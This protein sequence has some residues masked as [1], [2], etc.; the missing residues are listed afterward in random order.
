MCYLFAY[1]SLMTKQSVQSHS[2]QQTLQNL[3]CG[4]TPVAQ[5]HSSITIPMSRLISP[6][7]KFSAE[8]FA[9]IWICSH[10]Q[11]RNEG[12]E[13]VG[14]ASTWYGGAAGCCK[15]GPLS[16]CHDTWRQRHPPNSC[17]TCRTMTEGLP[18]SGLIWDTM[19]KSV[20]RLLQ[21]QCHVDN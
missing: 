1:S 11:Q 18:G 5:Q 17:V 12:K 6:G 8:D 21:A 9:R 7:S 10:S 14:L 20:Q 2:I 4:K 13:Y 15:A 3:Q 16:H 19:K